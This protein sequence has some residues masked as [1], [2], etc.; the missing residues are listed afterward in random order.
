MSKLRDDDDDV[1]T[2]EE[3]AAKAALAAVP[4]LGPAKEYGDNGQVYI[5][6]HFFIPGAGAAKQVAGIFKGKGGGDEAESVIS[7]DKQDFRRGGLVS[8]SSSRGR[9][10]AAVLSRIGDAGLVS[11]ELPESIQDYVTVEIRASH[12]RTMAHLFKASKARLTFDPNRKIE[13]GTDLLQALRA[14]PGEPLEPLTRGRSRW[15]VTQR[16]LPGLAAGLVE[17]YRGR[18]GGPDAETIVSWHKWTPDR[19]SLC[20]DCGRDIAAIVRRVGDDGIL[21]FKV[22]DK[23]AWPIFIDI[24]ADRFRTFAHAFRKTPRG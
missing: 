3:E 19:V 14:L 15:Q 7:W 9:D 5:S 10:V 2:P 20:S 17:I 12:F 4:R 16:P 24:R 13:S 23:P 6:Q 11:M 1:L 21:S 8:F 22:P 18:G